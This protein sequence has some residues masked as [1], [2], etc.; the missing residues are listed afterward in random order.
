MP[1]AIWTVVR[2][3]VTSLTTSSSSTRRQA[4]RSRLNPR[5]HCWDLSDS[6]RRS[7]M[8]LSQLTLAPANWSETTLPK[9]ANNSLKTPKMLVSSRNEKKQEELHHRVKPSWRRLTKRHSLHSTSE[10]IT[11]TIQRWRDGLAPQS[12]PQSIIRSLTREFKSSWARS[13]LRLL[14][15]TRAIRCQA[16]RMTSSIQKTELNIGWSRNWPRKTTASS[17]LIRPE[18]SADRRSRSSI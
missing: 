3:P 11:M 12:Q 13:S 16:Q 1:W 18:R 15:Q 4:R 7:E 5:P 6:G 14:A 2:A 17:G 9:S 8:S 10:G